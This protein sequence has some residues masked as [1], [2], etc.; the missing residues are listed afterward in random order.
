[1]FVFFGCES[2]VLI[3][4]DAQ[5]ISGHRTPYECRNRLT[6]IPAMK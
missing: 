4:E 5:G 3:E 1:M 6:D 2:G